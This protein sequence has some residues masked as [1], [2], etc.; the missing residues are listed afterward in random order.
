M[1]APAGWAWIEG[2]VVPLAEASVPLDDPGF[3]LGDGVFE[4][5]RGRRGRL[6]EWPRH[7]AR[8]AHGLEVL[9]IATAGLETVQEA[10]KALAAV[11]AGA[12]DDQYLRVQMVRVPGAGTSIPG[13]LTALVRP[14][15]EYPAHWYE[16]G[17]RLGVAEWRCDPRSPLAGVKSLSYLPQVLARRRVQAQ[18][19]DDALILNTDG[20]VCESAHGNVIARLGRTLY[21]PGRE[22]G[23]LAGVTRDVLLGWARD[24]GYEIEIRL[25]WD[26]LPMADEVVLA[27]TLAGVVPVATV[28]GLDVRFAGGNGELAAAMRQAY[29]DMLGA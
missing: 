24:N 15:P 7:R 16:S 14:L 19:F 5:L 13:R 29:E 11:G 18:G 26:V 12:F 3:L 6:F 28:E 10:L 27:S 25:P 21:T 23:A 8:M 20:R 2:S 22:E 17:V 1:N 9:G 4:T